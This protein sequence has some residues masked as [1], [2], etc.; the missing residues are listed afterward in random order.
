MLDDTP[1]VSS[2]NEPRGILTPKVMPAIASVS[3]IKTIFLLKLSIK[4]T[5]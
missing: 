2:V 5:H 1:Q 3:S 4:I